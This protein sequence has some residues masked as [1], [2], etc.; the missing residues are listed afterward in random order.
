ME[1]ELNNNIKLNDGCLE[2]MVL[3]WWGLLN[4]FFFKKKIQFSIF[5]KYFWKF[6]LILF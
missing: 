5:Y 3:S 1:E 4:Q 6:F 2:E